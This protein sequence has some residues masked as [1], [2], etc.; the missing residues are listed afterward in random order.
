MPWTRLMQ[1]SSSMIKFFLHSLS[2]GGQ[3]LSGS[4]NVHLL[5]F[6]NQESALIHFSF[7][8]TICLW[9][10]L[11][12]NVCVGL[13]SIYNCGPV[14]AIV[15]LRTV[16]TFYLHYNMC[17][18]LRVMYITCVTIYWMLPLVYFAGLNTPRTID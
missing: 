14:N 8:F 10:Q 12:K 16:S 15:A 5:K 4:R 2:H 13:C 3:W 9:L 7:S 1:Y 17:A 18:Q 6:K 11:A